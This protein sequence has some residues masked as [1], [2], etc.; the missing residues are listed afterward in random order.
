MKCHESVKHLIYKE[1][2]NWTLVTVTKW[3]KHNLSNCYLSW[4]EE[5]FSFSEYISS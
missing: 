4:K 2:P 1:N 3:W 5:R